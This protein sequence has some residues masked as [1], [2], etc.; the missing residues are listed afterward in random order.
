[1]DGLE[2][3]VLDRKDYVMGIG[4]VLEV[5]VEGPLEKLELVKVEGP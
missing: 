1:M 5:S 3:D 2:P 4:E